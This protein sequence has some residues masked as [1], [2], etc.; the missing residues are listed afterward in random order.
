MEWAEK[1]SHMV[2]GLHRAYARGSLADR[3]FVLTW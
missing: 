3:G 2:F 1:T